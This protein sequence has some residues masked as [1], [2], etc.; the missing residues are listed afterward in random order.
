MAAILLKSDFAA[1]LLPFET[2]AK[3]F[4]IRV[5]HVNY[6]QFA[7]QENN[8]RGYGSLKGKIEMSD[9]F[10]DPLDDFKEYM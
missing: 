10:D 4:G 7:M 1:D 9:D 6:E 3:R 5:E 2:M 8:N